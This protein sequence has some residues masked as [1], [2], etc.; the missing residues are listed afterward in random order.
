MHDYAFTA[1]GARPVLWRG[2]VSH[3]TRCPERGSAVHTSVDTRRGPFEPR[4]GGA[5]DVNDCRQGWLPYHRYV[6]TTVSTPLDSR[7]CGRACSLGL[8]IFVAHNDLIILDY[9]YPLSIFVGRQG[10]RR[11]RHQTDT[12]RRI[13][14][15]TISVR[16]DEAM[17]LEQ[18]RMGQLPRSFP[19]VLIG[20]LPQERGGGVS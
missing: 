14:S 4:R 1:R 7:Q 9:T 16:G 19:R 2:C 6:L 18:N 15:P 5:V 8:R 20:N 12:E 17:G 13:L 10:T 11:V 3:R